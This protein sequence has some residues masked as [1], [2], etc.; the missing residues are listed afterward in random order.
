MIASFDASTRAAKR[1]ALAT[2]RP[3]CS[4]SLFNR[5]VKDSQHDRGDQHEQ[6]QIVRRW[7]QTV[8][9]ALER[10]PAKDRE[11]HDGEWQ[12]PP[13]YHAARS[14]AGQHLD[15]HPFRVPG[16]DPDAQDQK[17]QS[18]VESDRGEASGPSQF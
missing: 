16:G 10:K 15:E 2:A 17:R 6:R 13:R 7:V 8:A 12:Q 5:L 14:L 1:T 9:V 3:R 18:R 4:S 11:K